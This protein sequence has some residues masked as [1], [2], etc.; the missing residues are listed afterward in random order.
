VQITLNVEFINKLNILH[1]L[2]KLISLLSSVLSFCGAP[3]IEQDYPLVLSE[4][5][6]ATPPSPISAGAS[7]CHATKSYLGQRIPSPHPIK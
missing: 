6:I 5:P 7:H 3:S 4:H 2:L 1:F